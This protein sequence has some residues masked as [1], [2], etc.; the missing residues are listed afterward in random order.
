MSKLLKKN[1]FVWIVVI[2]A[3][4]AGFVAPNINESF[5]TSVYQWPQ[6]TGWGPHWW[7]KWWLKPWYD[8][9]NFPKINSSMYNNSSRYNSC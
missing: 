6:R 7:S 2:I 9:S 4:L 8:R 1:K 3:I 5:F